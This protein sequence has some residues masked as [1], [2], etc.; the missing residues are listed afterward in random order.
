MHGIAFVPAGFPSPRNKAQPVTERTEPIEEPAVQPATH[1]VADQAALSVIVACHNYEAF[2]GRAIASVTEQR[3]PGVELIVVDDGSTDRSWEVIVDLAARA[4]A[5]GQPFAIHRIANQGQRCACL[6]GFER[7]HAP[8][9]LFLDADDELL[10][11]SIGTIL[12]QLDANVAKLQFP[13]ERI[14]ADGRSMGEPRPVLLE[15]REREALKA[16]VLRSGSYTTPPTSGNV[17]RRDLCTL[18][19]EAD[20]DAA[21]DGIILFAA[22]F[23]GDVVSLATPLGRYRLHD[24]NDSGI[25][26]PP[27]PRSIARDLRRFEDRTAHLRRFLQGH[28]LDDHLVKA[29]DA[30]FH[31]ERSLYLAMTLGL[32]PGM[33]EAAR[34]IAG[35]AGEPHS[36]KAKLALAGFFAMAALLP[37]KRARRALAW[38]LDARQRSPS[39]LIRA[40][41]GP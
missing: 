21:V 12:G 11:G 16:R 5:E 14:D 41:V 38:R 37:Q 8:F 35:L 31:R 1:R 19:R 33:G 25:N 34:L 39:G 3:H 26:R 27:D 40:V 6:Y 28:G 10:P 29:E 32:R 9:I 36:R 2:V 23:M 24:R 17:F 15:A 13:L 30:Y 22:P 4:E 7:S 18:L 20:Y